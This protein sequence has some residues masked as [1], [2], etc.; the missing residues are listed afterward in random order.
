MSRV[1]KVATEY[2]M[3]DGTIVRVGD[4]VTYR[5]G[6]DENGVFPIG[7]VETITKEWGRWHAKVHLLAATNDNY[8][9]YNQIDVRLANF[10]NNLAF[11]NNEDYNRK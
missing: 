6:A 4:M 5:W 9:R 2:T 8:R 1:Q 11:V 10:H 7:F 3:K